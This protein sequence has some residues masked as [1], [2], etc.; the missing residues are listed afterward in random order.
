MASCHTTEKDSTSKLL[1]DKRLTK[2][3]ASNEKEESYEDQRIECEKQGK[4]SE[5]P[6]LPLEKIYSYVR[7]Q[8]Q[9]NMSLVCRKWSEG[10]YSPSVWRTFRFELTKSQLL[11]DTCKL[12]KF[13]QKHSNLFRH[14]E[15]ERTLVK[16]KKLKKNWRRRFAEF[17]Q[18]LTN[19]TQLISIKFE[20]CGFLFWESE[21]TTYNDVYKE[22]ADFLGSQYHL[23]RVE[24][25]VCNFYFKESAEI[26]SKLIEGSRRSLK[27]L[28]L[29]GFTYYNSMDQEQISNV[30]QYLSSHLPTLA[31]FPSLIILEIDYSLIFE[32]IIAPLS[33]SIQ[34][35]K[36]SQTRGLSK[37]IL[38]FHHGWMGIEEFRGLTS[39]DWQFLQ[40]LCPDLKVEFNFIRSSLSWRE[41]TFF[42][43]PN[44]PILSLKFMNNRTD[45]EVAELFNHLLACNTN[46]HLVTLHLDWGKRIQHLSSIFAPFLHA[47]KKLKSLELFIKSTTND[48]NLLLNSWLENPHATLEKVII[49]ASGDIHA[50]DPSL[51]NLISENVSRLKLMGLNIWLHLS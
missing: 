24:F 10:F 5:L 35:I 25:N 30:M 42:I 33:N 50:S 32:S 37:I 1:T 49:Y 15:I 11:E 19:S 20:N 40:K 13:V 38:N 34:T 6:S 36:K 3:T 8:D 9:L 4:W 29:R 16:K 28:V 48:I 27:H 31:D 12:M 44:M 41:V 51:L 39:T 45:L 2:S 43:L 46:G 17:L 22:I 23:Q 14:V 26:L 21:T 47:C 7:R 18:I